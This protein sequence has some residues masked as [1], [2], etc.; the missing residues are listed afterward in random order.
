M[1]RFNDR[2][3][4]IGDTIRKARE[5]KKLTKTKLCTELELLGVNFTRDELYKIERYKASVKD[6]ELIALCKVLEID[7]NTIQKLI[8][9]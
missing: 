7:F 2:M 4:V 9:I 5:E 3:N 1:K 8:E 6:F